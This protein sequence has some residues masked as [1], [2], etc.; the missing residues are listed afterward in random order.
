MSTYAVS[1]PA[2]IGGGC[3][4]F[5]LGRFLATGKRAATGEFSGQAQSLIGAVLLSS[6]ILLTGFQV[7]GSWSALSDARSSTYDEARALADTYW[8]VGGLAPADRAKVRTLLRT[9]TDDVRTVEFPVLSHGG[10][11]P[12]AWQDLDAV[13]AAVRTAP[14]SGAGPQAAKIAAQS[15]LDTVYRTRTDRAAQVKGRMPAATWIAML[16][17][18]AFLIAFPALLGLTVT[19]R[20]LTALCF[21]GAAVAFAIC[22]AAQLNA[23]FQRPF[24]VRPTAFALADARYA[25]I[26]AERSGGSTAPPR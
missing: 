2:T 14:A 4:A 16:V 20:H 25:Q 22:L 1:L 24:G 9:Y 21:V 12:T 18:G 15:A 8:A 7:A 19:A 10:T 23:P 26:D 5:L 6:F 3:F 11:S 13:R 17:A